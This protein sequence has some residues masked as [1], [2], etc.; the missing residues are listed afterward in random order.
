[1]LR[2]SKWARNSSHSSSVGV[3]Y[4][5][6]GRAYLRRAMKP[7]WGSMASAG[8]SPLA[9]SHGRVDVALAADDLGDVGR[10]TV[11]DRVGDEDPAEVVWGEDQ[12][13]A[14]VAVDAGA[15]QGL[16]EDL[17][18]RAVADGP[19]FADGTGTEPGNVVTIPSQVST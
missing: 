15:G 10:Q 2:F 5:S 4:S 19:A 11:H 6:L 3:R 1:S 13:L 8:R 7:R 18:H 16:L 12:G 17:S 9:T 14:V